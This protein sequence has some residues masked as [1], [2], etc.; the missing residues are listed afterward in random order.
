MS[1]FVEQRQDGV[2]INLKSS[3]KCEKEELRPNE[4]LSYRIQEVDWKSDPNVS[5]YEVLKDLPAIIEGLLKPEQQ[6]IDLCQP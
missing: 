3:R 2:F 4:V 6:P 5:F 1:I